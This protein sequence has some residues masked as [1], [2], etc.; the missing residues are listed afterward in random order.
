MS[1]VREDVL[2]IAHLARLAIDEDAVVKYSQELSNI[3]DLVAQMD[4][5]E[6]GDIKPMAHPFAASQRL[7]PDLITETDQHE[8]YQSIAPAV[9]TGLYL[10]PI[11]IDN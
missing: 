2:K 10:V 11:V 1:L 6:I 8:L 4:T 9:Q 7:R 3:L 5:V